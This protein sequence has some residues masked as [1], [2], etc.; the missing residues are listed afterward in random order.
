MA[1]NVYE[2]CQDHYDDEYYR[3]SPGTNPTG[4]DGGQEPLYEAGAT[5][6]RH[7]QHC[8]RPTE[9]ERKKGRRAILLVFAW[10]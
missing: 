1:G 6:R 4:P 9:L 5:R 7:G 3:A 10:L 2:W 8:A